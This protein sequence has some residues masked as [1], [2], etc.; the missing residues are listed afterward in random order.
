MYR[1]D[2]EME[3]REKAR[4]MRKLQASQGYQKHVTKKQN[5][6]R[7]RKGSRSMQW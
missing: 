3:R 1:S 4:A 2:W 7:K 5:S 6:S